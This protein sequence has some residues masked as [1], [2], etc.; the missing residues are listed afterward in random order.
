LAI[1]A[2]V[3]MTL[4][5]DEVHE[6][7]PNENALRSLVVRL[8]GIWDGDPDQHVQGCVGILIDSVLEG[9][10]NLPYK[11]FLGGAKAI[12]LKQIEDAAASAKWNPDGF[13]A[14]MVADRGVKLHEWSLEAA[15]HCL[16]SPGVL[17]TAAI[18]LSEGGGDAAPTGQV[19]PPVGLPAEATSASPDHVR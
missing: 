12:T 13:L 6:R 1:D 17:A 15:R 3:Q 10:N 14:R 18:E 8:Y 5:C 11:E 9:L 4:A 19:S 16:F 7:Q 2:L